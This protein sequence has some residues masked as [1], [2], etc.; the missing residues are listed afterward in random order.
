LLLDNERL[1]G[2]FRAGQSWGRRRQLLRSRLQCEHP[3]N[4][5]LWSSAGVIHVI[6]EPDVHPRW[7]SHG[8]TVRSIPWEAIQFAQMASC[9]PC[10]SRSDTE[11]LFSSSRFRLTRSTMPKPSRSPAGSG[12]PH[13]HDPRTSPSS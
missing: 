13:R 12:G 7:P 3:D 2:W 8:V 9:R 1:Y 5:L 11:S 6:H 4:L 10:V